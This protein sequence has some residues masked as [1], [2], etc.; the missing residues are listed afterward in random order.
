MKILLTTVAALAIAGPAAAAQLVTNGGF[1]TGTLAGW[2]GPIGNTGFSSVTT[3]T[4]HTGRFNY[5]NGAVGS[6]GTISQVLSTL[7]GRSYSYSFWLANESSSPT[8]S[9][10][11]TFGTAVLSGLS[12][13][14]G[15][16]YTLFS[17]THVTSSANETLS[18]AFRHDPSFWR[19]DDVS[20]TGAIPEPASWA[21]LI[22]GFGLVGVAARR[23][24]TVVTA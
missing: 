14:A 2:T 13:S 21:M 12:N 5:R 23:R 1:E 9:F 18:F 16:G 20:V 3:A 10:Q 11:A 8:N 17:G 24:K 4:P 19:L 7:A 6:T 15:F 22:V